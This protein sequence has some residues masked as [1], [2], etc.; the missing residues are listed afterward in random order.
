MPHSTNLLPVSRKTLWAII[1][2]TVG[3][4]YPLI[5]SMK[6]TIWLDKT[7]RPERT[8]IVTGATGVLGQPTVHHMAERKCRVIMAC[9]DMQKCK[10]I[11]RE[12]VLLTKN[13]SIVCRHLDLEDID[14]INKFADQM[15]NTEPHIDVIVNN[16]AVKDIRSKELTKYGIEKHLFVNFLAPYLLTLKLMSKLE[17]SAKVT[18][19]SRIVNVIGNPQY[20]WHIDLLDINFEKRKY[21]SGEAYNQSKLALAYFSILLEKLNREKRNKVY[22]FGTSPSTNRIL[23]DYRHETGFWA[24]LKSVYYEYRYQNAGRVCQRTVKCALDPGLVREGLSGKLYNWFLDS[25]GSNNG[26]GV[27]ASNE[28]KAK[29]VWNTAADM[30]LNA[31]EKLVKPDEPP[32]RT[33][34][35]TNKEVPSGGDQV[36]VQGNN[37]A[38]GVDESA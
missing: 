23:P 19:D 1:A 33:S 14:S 21:T 13:K 20:S 17:E 35:T 7:P 29:L 34:G 36:K 25:Y 5:N 32:Q 24:E 3:L 27:A 8:I 30:L 9:R 15:I 16:A 22:V 26:W 6:H 38:S 28:E 11:R 18:D 37:K 2:G 12:L 4:T 10:A 31:K